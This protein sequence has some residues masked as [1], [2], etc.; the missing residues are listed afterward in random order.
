MSQ[1][2][3]NKLDQALAIIK[4]NPII[5]DELASK[6]NTSHRITM[7]VIHLLRNE[8][9]EICIKGETIYLAKNSVKDITMGAMCLVGIPMILFIF[10]G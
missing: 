2:V 1:L 7:D 8:H 3:T 5:L 4:Q 10:W 6:L 9:S